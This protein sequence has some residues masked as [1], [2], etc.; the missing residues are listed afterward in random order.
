MTKYTAIIAP[1][2]VKT[3]FGSDMMRPLTDDTIDVPSK[4]FSILPKPPVLELF[5]NDRP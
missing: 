1:N 5:S 3:A 4:Y 2:A